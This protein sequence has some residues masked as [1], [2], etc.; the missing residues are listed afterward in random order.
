MDDHVKIGGPHF[1]VIDT[2]YTLTPKDAQS[3]ELKVTMHYRINTE[4]NWYA[5][6]IAQL[7]IG[8]FEDVVLNFYSKR[9]AGGVSKS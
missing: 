6:P 8:N 1:D 9:A 4:F 2:E 5:D 7:L 3:T